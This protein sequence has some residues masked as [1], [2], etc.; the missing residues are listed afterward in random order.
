MSDAMS[1]ALLDA[2]KNRL[3][4]CRGGFPQR[5]LECEELEAQLTPG[6]VAEVRQLA[7]EWYCASS[8]PRPPSAGPVGVDPDM[9]PPPATRYS[10]FG[11]G[12]T[13]SCGEPQWGPSGG[14]PSRSP[15]PTRS[16]PGE[17]GYSPTSPNYSPTGPAG[18]Y[19]PTAGAYTPTSPNYTPVSVSRGASR[20]PSP[21]S[22]SYCPTSPSYSR[23]SPG[24]TPSP[25]PSPKRGRNT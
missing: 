10:P 19:D 14:S 20:S 1:V 18:G 25:E 7:F 15:T 4:A 21:T 24:R 2:W 22:A 13:F 11:D 23:T 9:T 12:Y 16:H 8:E 5:V 17:P 6:V 3:T